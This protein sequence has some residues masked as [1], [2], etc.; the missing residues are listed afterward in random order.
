MVF[1][2]DAEGNTFLPLLS[3]KANASELTFSISTVTTSTSSQKL[4]TSW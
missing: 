3:R 1:S 4:I 2:V